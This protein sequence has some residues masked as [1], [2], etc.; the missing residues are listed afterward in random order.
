MGSRV[1]RGDVRNWNGKD[2]SARL[3]LI[4]LNTG[5][6]AVSHPKYM[7]NAIPVF[8]VAMGAHY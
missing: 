3:T 1:S 2:T 8:G 4:G 7:R 6:A 5:A